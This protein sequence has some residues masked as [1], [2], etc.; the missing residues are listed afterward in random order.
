[1]ARKM[2]REREVIRIQKVARGH[3]MRLK[4]P[5]VRREW[6]ALRFQRYWRGKKGRRRAHRRLVRKRRRHAAL[7]LQTL[8][9]AYSLMRGFG[10]VCE[11]TYCIQRLYRSI[12]GRKLWMQARLLHS[13]THAATAVQRQWRGWVHR[14]KR[15]LAYQ[16]PPP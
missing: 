10:R 12:R 14:R 16:V 13:N 3:A 15:W 11:A 1:M 6:A 7:V 4:L 8:C 5:T 2:D 9:R